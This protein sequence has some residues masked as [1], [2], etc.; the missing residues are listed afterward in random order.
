MN[1]ATTAHA[2]AIKETLAGI[3]ISLLPQPAERILL[4][5][6]EYS[7]VRNQCHARFEEDK[8]MGELL[9]MNKDLLSRSLSVLKRSLVV[10][11]KG[12]A[13]SINFPTTSWKAPFRGSDA[14]RAKQVELDLWLH[15]IKDPDLPLVAL[16]KA[17][18]SKS[19]RAATVDSESTGDRA[20]YIEVIESRESTDISNRV[21]DWRDDGYIRDKLSKAPGL[22]QELFDGKTRLAGKEF[23]KLYRRNPARCRVLIG[24]AITK[25]NP[26]AW[27][28]TSVINELS[29]I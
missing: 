16:P 14:Q 11:I 1:S 9:V 23:P 15:R 5:I 13:H 12:T 24:D 8:Q 21:G 2:R 17:V 28:N 29:P 27:F 6:L 22:S 26:N 18:D 20:P 4:L 19:T 10:S 7:H 25:D 3:R